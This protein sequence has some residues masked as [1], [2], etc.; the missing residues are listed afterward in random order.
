MAPY[1]YDH[2]G[3]E[4][5]GRVEDPRH[6]GCQVQLCE[7]DQHVRHGRVAQTKHQEAAIQSDQI[8]SL[9][10]QE[11][12]GGQTQTG[13]A[14]PRK[15]HHQGSERVHRH[16]DEQI[17]RAQIAASKTRAARLR[18]LTDGMNPH[19]GTCQNTTRSVYGECRPT[20]VIGAEPAP[21]GFSRH[22]NLRP[23]FRSRW[24]ERL[25]NRVARIINRLPFVRRGFQPPRRR[26]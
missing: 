6:R 22:P 17:G 15:G 11:G 24:H 25:P 16:P 1:R 10:D 26:A 14:D 4:G 2:R 9:A 3:E 23:G 12:V 19:Y 20:S 7:G 8:V 5:S 18:V 21:V 13:R